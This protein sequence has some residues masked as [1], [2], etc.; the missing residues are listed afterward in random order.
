MAQHLIAHYPLNSTANDTTGNN[1]PMTLVNTPFLDGGIYCNGVYGG[2]VNPDYCIAN[3]P[4]L[5]NFNM[6]SFSIS[7]YFKVIDSLTDLHPV[8]VGGQSYRWIAFYLAPDSTV[9]LKYNN[10]NYE[11]SNVHYALN[12]WHLA[13]ITYK[14]SVAKLYLDDTLAVL[15]K[16]EMIH[17]NDKDIGIIDL[18]SGRTFKG[19]FR[20]LKIYNLDTAVTDIK[21]LSNITP[22]IA[23]LHQN[24]PNPFNPTTTIS[25]QS[26]V[27]SHQSLKVFD[28][29]GNEVATLIDEYREAGKYEVKFNAEGLSSGIYFYKLQSGYF[30]ETK[31]MILLR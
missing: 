25:W 9:L 15:I 18:A 4:I 19:V 12:K 6:S 31:K 24:Y 26:P 22:R 2:G 23:N 16:F 27:G 28:M 13:T 11:L 30:V 5:Q 3:T 17:G 1:A 14:D 21:T 8:F 29:L 10:N 7:A 20:D